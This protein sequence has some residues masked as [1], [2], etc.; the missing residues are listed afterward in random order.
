MRKWNKGKSKHHIKRVKELSECLTDE[1]VY[2]LCDQTNLCDEEEERINYEIVDLEDL[3]QR[4]YSLRLS[5]ATDENHRNFFTKQ[6]QIKSEEIARLEAK[7]S[8]LEQE[9]YVV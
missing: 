5:R 7:L 9:E 2:D 6:C 3:R 1:Q 4:L 8:Y